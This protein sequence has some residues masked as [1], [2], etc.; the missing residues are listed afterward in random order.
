MKKR[1]LC[2]AAAAIMA[3][4]AVSASAATLPIPK[5]NADAFKLAESFYYDGLY[6]E[7]KD[8]LGYV[9]D[10]PEYEKPKAIE[11]TK[12]VDWAI[13]RMEIK[14]LLKEVKKYSNLGFYGLADDVI[15][16]LNARKDLIQEDYYTIR[17][18]EEVIAAKLGKVTF[19]DSGS[20]AIRAVKYTKYK[21]ASNREWF[22]PVKVENGYHVYVQTQLPGGGSANVAAFRVSVFGDVVEVPYGEF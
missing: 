8:M 3:L 10:V 13:S 22:M 7:A 21:L 12:R 20:D 2:F 5:N 18:W 11:W 17:W 19:V 16:V 15:N 6:Y 4:S 1:I 14:E 9:K